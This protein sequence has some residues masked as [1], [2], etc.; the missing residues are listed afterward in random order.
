MAI[1]QYLREDASKIGI[2]VPEA[3]LRIEDVAVRLAAV[4]QVW[5]EVLIYGSK[6]AR[7][8]DV[9]GVL[10]QSRPN[11]IDKFTVTTNIHEFLSQGLGVDLAV[12][13]FTEFARNG[14]R[15]RDLES[16]IKSIGYRYL[17][18]RGFTGLDV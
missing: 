4:D 1:Q 8:R 16:I 17:K 14:F 15:W 18:F 6:K 11:R 5:I 3:Y 10:M 7:D 2:D 9:P 12:S 13:L